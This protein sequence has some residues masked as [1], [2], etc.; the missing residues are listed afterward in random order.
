M[1]DLTYIIPARIESEDRLKNIITSVS[2]LLRNFPEAKVIVKEVSD[3]ERFKFKA[4]PEISKFCNTDNLKYVFEKS[5]DTLFHKT[6][7][8]N[9]LIMLL[10]RV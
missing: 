8:L 9:D 5:V 3:R 10:K 7:I 1:N 6:R 2:Y 4:F